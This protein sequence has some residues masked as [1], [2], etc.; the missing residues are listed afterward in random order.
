M[1]AHTLRAFIVLFSPSCVTINAMGESHRRI[2]HNVHW[3][4]CAVQI[5]NESYKKGGRRNGKTT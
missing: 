4:N 1:A 5:L 3:R 2:H